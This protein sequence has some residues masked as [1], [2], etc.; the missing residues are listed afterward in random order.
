MA[1][2]PTYPAIPACPPSTNWSTLDLGAGTTLNGA[3]FGAATSWGTLS[4]VETAAVH[5][6]IDAGLDC[7]VRFVDIGAVSGT[8]LEVV[9]DTGDAPQTP[10]P[11]N[12]ALGLILMPGATLVANQGYH[13]AIVKNPTPVNRG[14]SISRPG[15]G[16]LAT[17]AAFGSAGLQC[18]LITRFTGGGTTATS[19]AA[20]DSSDVAIR[21]TVTEVASLGAY[22]SV[23][24]GIY[25]TQQGAA[26]ATSLI[27]PNVAI[28]YR[29][30]S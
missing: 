3:M 22:A 28:R 8:V 11:A 30:S 9:L 27:W 17:G 14:S 24:V 15:G 5:G 6:Y 23:K 26:P 20:M 25:N 10:A 12:S 4:T 19:C 1:V 21:S 7:G 13:T 2:R 29:W 16:D 18:R